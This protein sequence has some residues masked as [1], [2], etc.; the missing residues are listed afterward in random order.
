MY[1][2]IWWAEP[3]ST[4][5]LA[6][7]LMVGEGAAART[8]VAGAAVTNWSWLVGRFRPGSVRPK[9]STASG[10]ASRPG[11]AAPFCGKGFLEKL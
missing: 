4:V 1:L 8:K 6:D 7:V 10:R 2:R 3:G 5:T 11:A 9:L